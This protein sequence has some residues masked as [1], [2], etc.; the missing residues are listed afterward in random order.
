MNFFSLSEIESEI[1]LLLKF[2]SRASIAET[3]IQKRLSKVHDLF[4]P[5]GFSL[6]ENEYKSKIDN[7]VDEVND[8]LPQLALD[9]EQVFLQLKNKINDLIEAKKISTDGYNQLSPLMSKDNLTK[10]DK[11]LFFNIFKSIRDL[12]IKDIKIIGTKEVES[13]LSS[14]KKIFIKEKSLVTNLL[15]IIEECQNGM[16]SCYSRKFELI[17]HRHGEGG[18]GSAWENF[19]KIIDSPG[20]ISKRLRTSELNE[21]ITYNRSLRDMDLYAPSVKQNLL[22]STAVHTIE[23]TG[24][25]NIV[26]KKISTSG[27][28]ERSGYKFGAESDDKYTHK[29]YF[30]NYLLKDFGISF[31]NIEES[32]N[33]LAKLNFY[34]ELT[35]DTEVTN[36]Y[37]IMLVE[38]R[39]LEESQLPN[40]HRKIIELQSDAKKT[41]DKKNEELE[42][43]RN[44]INEA[45]RYF[46]SLNLYNRL[47]AKSKKLNYIYRLIFNGKTI[48]TLKNNIIIQKGDEVGIVPKS[49]ISSIEKMADETALPVPSDLQRIKEMNEKY[50]AESNSSQA[51]TAYYNYYKLLKSLD[52]EINNLFYK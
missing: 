23:T 45:L 30:L 48:D 29:L 12:L 11:I 42:N 44:K 19:K 10:E 5:T 26:A 34:S 14:Y 22:F 7:Y 50:E 39:K 27:Y 16:L 43:C 46:K 33:F 40:I 3:P 51:K 41:N 28:D 17:E 1:N 15:Q 47:E 49:G 31:T 4:T 8:L 35:K 9:K 2:A 6:E 32:R 25:Q 18:A 20:T 24:G 38:I 36:P 37:K 13:Y 52:S 21:E